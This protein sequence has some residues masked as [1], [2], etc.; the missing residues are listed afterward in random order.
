MILHAFDS[1]LRPARFLRRYKRFLADVE[2]EDGAVVTIHCPNPG[3]MLGLCA[4]GAPALLA[5]ARA[6]AKLPWRLALIE[7]DGVWVGVDTLLPNRLAERALQAGLVPGLPPHAGLRREARYGARN[8]RVDFLLTDDSGAPAG[9]VEVKNVHLRRAPG[10]AEFPD[11]VTARGAKHL[12]ELSD[13]AGAGGFA[14]MLY[15]VQREDCGRLAMAADLDPGYAEAFRAAR[16]AGVRACALVC[17]M[18]PAGARFSHHA[19]IMA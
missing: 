4:P 9:Y 5:P 18:S 6:G 19:A 15:V 11:C 8:S 2:M 14:M 12:A 16:A 13:I 17:A 10:L 3:A 1:P 7:A